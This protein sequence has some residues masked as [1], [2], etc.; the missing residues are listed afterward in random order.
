MKTLFDSI[1]DLPKKKGNPYKNRRGK[2]TDQSTARID[3]AEKERDEW[4]KRAEYFESLY[5]GAGTM[6]R[7]KD[8]EIL[9]LKGQ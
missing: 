9:K 6:L 8:N 1:I 4:K 3:Q 7:L 2:Y 5:R